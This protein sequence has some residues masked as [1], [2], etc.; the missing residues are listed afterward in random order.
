MGIEGVRLDTNVSRLTDHD[1]QGVV[2]FMSPSDAQVYHI[3]IKL[4]ERYRRGRF[5]QRKEDTYLLAEERFDVHID[6][7][8]KT[9]YEY[10][11][12]MDF[13]PLMS[14]IDRLAEQSLIM[15]GLVAVA[16][17]VK[18]AESELW[19]TVTAKVKGTA[20]HPFSKKRID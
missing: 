2:T 20:L 16:K 13:S 12:H 14:P 19:L 9:P 11:F 10:R 8:E 7:E 18:G 5:K 1:L 3:H 17:K 4:E 6:L 15:K